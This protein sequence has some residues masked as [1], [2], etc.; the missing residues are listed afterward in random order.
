ML[1]SVD[2]KG[3][4]VCR[5]LGENMRSVRR[6]WQKPRSC[7]DFFLPEF[8][9]FL[10]SSSDMEAGVR[11]HG[12]IQLS[13]KKAFVSLCSSAGRKTFSSWSGTQSKCSFWGNKLDF[14]V[15]GKTRVSVIAYTNQAVPSQNKRNEH[16]SQQKTWQTAKLPPFEYKCYK[17][18]I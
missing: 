9:Q 15:G 7:S 10:C 18:V 5:R 12:I 16:G 2:K 13:K 8:N 4:P 17:S 6:I 1:C 3:L 14:C 11:P